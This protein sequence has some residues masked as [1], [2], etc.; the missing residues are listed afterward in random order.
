[1]S[2]PVLISV[3]SVLQHSNALATSSARLFQRFICLKALLVFPLSLCDILRL[4]LPSDHSSR[5]AFSLSL[6]PNTASALQPASSK[7]ESV[8]CVYLCTCSFACVLGSGGADVNKKKCMLILCVL[9]VYVN[10]FSSVM[11]CICLG[12]I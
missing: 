6:T 12:F 8:W 11:K 3:S 4:C 9:I 10:C 2:Y 7:S 5:L 1:M